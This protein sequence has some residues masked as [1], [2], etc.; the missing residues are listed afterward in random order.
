MRKTDLDIAAAYGAMAALGTASLAFP[1]RPTGSK[2]VAGQLQ[3]FHRLGPRSWD[4]R[5]Y[6]D[7]RW[8]RGRG[9][10][11]TAALLNALLAQ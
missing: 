6:R 5:I 7:G 1:A 8:H 2:T 3:K 11:K 4:C 9:T 10:T